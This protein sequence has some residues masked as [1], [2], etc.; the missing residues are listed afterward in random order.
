MSRW[1]GLSF[2]AL[3][4]T[5]NA[6]VDADVL[7]PAPD[8]E[9]TPIIGGTAVPPGK[10]PDTVAVIGNMG[11]C[12]G[13]L[14]APDVVLTAGHCAQGMTQ[15]IA[16]TTNYAQAGGVRSTIK[17]ITAY[18]NWETSYDIAVVV[19]NTPITGVTPRPIGTS[20]TF[21]TFSAKPTVRLVGFGLTDNQ[22]QGNNTALYEVDVPVTDPVCTGNG[23]QPTISPGGE[24]V[25][26]GGNKDSCN[27]DSG[28]PVYLNTPR[29]YV[30]IGAVSRALS[31]ATVPCGEGGIYVRTDKVV[32]WIEQTAG[33]SVSK[34]MCNTQP[35]PDDEEG[36]GSGTGTGTGTGGGNGT[37][38][39]DGAATDVVGGCSTTG[40]SGASLAFL[41]LGLAALRR[42]R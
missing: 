39:G 10:W 5:A 25:A 42:R 40:G 30:V 23:C 35:P 26:G 6:A 19:L 20:C 15:V 29:G 8:S 13:T 33:K 16:N 28:G 34:D 2:L 9:A 31:N 22:A 4:S 1:L 12:T 18:P 14:I 41:L 3:A 21:E 7:A 27:G 17:S 32:Q 37:G 24:F 11:S 38:G 36:G